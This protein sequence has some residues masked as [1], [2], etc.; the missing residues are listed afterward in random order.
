MTVAT[1][2]GA[3]IRDWDSFHT[4]SARELGFPAFYGR[5]MNAFVDCLTYLDQAD[6]MSRFSLLP[7][8][9]LELRVVDSAT[10]RQSAPEVAAAFVDA[11]T[12]INRRYSDRGKAEVIRLVLV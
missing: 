12:S 11:I 10:F 2:P 8:E 4:V 6:G 9:I 1:R 7:G 5:N 3:E